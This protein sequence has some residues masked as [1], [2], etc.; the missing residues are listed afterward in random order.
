MTASPVL[1]M[2]F[3]A[4]IGALPSVRTAMRR[5]LESL[6]VRGPA[7]DDIVLAS[8]EACANAVEHPLEAAE[9]LKAAERDVSID[10]KAD[11][12]HVLVLVRDAGSWR[13]EATRPYRGLGL[14]LVSAV[15][16]NVKIIRGEDGTIVRM[17]RCVERGP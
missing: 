2:R 1:S 9:Q 5:W 13:Q 10:A 15:M 17:C 3:A 14:T 7:A 16:D 4:D 8:W 6:G 12:S 11:G